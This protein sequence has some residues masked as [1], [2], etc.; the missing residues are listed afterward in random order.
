MASASSTATDGMLPLNFYFRGSRD[1][2]S[3]AESDDSLPIATAV[4]K[5][6]F[7]KRRSKQSATSTSM[8]FLGS[9]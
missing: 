5:P 6:P 3:T 1:A 8:I 9:N 2:D 7:T 4:S